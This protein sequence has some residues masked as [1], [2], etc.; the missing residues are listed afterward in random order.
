MP[1]ADLPLDLAVPRC[2]QISRSG[3]IGGEEFSSVMPGGSAVQAP[4]APRWAVGS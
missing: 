2:H 1:M 3:D 4:F